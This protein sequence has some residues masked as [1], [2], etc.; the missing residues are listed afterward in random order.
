VTIPNFFVPVT[1]FAWLCTSRFLLGIF[2]AII[3]NA[4]ACYIGDAVPKE[5]QVTVG[6]VI[7]T[8]IVLGLFVTAAFDLALPT[9]D[10]GKKTDELWR[11]SY[12][13]QLINVAITTF[14]WFFMH[15]EEPLKFL[16]T[17]AEKND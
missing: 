4:T 11:I 10:G 14:M 16:I 17:K 3:I 13:L 8:G 7:N 2:S 12:S 5:Y 15:K 9:D 6:T 1:A